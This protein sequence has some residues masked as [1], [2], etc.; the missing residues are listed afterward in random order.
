MQEERKGE[1]YMLALSI[2]ESWFPI[3]SLFS[4]ALIGAMYS[5]ALTISIAT[6]IFSILYSLLAYM[7]KL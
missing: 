1:I 5:Y 3:L 7:S 2:I 6:I 4:I